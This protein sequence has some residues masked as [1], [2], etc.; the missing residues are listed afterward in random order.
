M[1]NLPKNE[2]IYIC[3]R[4]LYID[5]FKN[6]KRIRKSTGL[7]NS[8]LAF[9]FVRKHYEQFINPTQNI[10]ELQKLYYEIE[11]KQVEKELSN[12]TKKKQNNLVESSFHKITENILKEKSFLK[13][14][15]NHTYISLR[16]HILQFLEENKLFYVSDFKREHSVLFLNTL[17]KQNLKPKTINSLCFFMKTIFNY[18]QDNDMIIKNPFFVPKMKQNLN[19]KEQ[20]FQVFNLEEITRLIKS[21][22]NDLRTF[23]VLAF[24]TGARTGEILA[25]KYEDLDFYNNQIH[26]YKSLSSRGIIDSPKTKSS[27]RSVDMLD[28]VR[29]ELLPLKQKHSLK[30]FIIQSKRYLLNKE[31]HQLLEKLNYQKRRLYDTRHSFAS[32]MLS[33]GEEPMWV[34]CKMMGHKDLNETYRSY[35]KYLPKKVVE[36]ATFLRNL[37]LSPLNFDIKKEN[38]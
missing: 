34:G 38:C 3:G 29:Q 36:R 33:K 26:I 17:Q 20:D 30:D 37:D 10:K 35:A 11:S 18:A 25:L 19:T 16:K 9:A 2:N 24:F 13:N 1:K 21:S 6:G 22:N 28:I 31:F 12:N 27:R 23:L 15:T 32:L 7:N 4:K 8:S 5:Y 14:N